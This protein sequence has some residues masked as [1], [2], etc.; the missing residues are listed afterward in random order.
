MSEWWLGAP[1]SITGMHHSGTS[2]V[3]ELLHR[4]GLYLGR[5]DQ[6]FASGSDNPD[7]YWEHKGFRA[8]NERILRI[9]G[10]GRNLP[11]SLPAGWQ[12]DERLRPLRS[13]AK[14]LL[15][16]FDGHERWGWKD[17]RNSL[18]LPFWKSLVPGVKVVVC[19]R[20][21]LQVAFEL[22]QRN[23]SSYASGLK[24]W[25]VYNQRLLSTLPTDRYIVT[26]YD[27]YFYRPQVEL[28][29]VLD[30]LRLPASDQLV[31][32]VSSSTLGNLRYGHVTTQQ[33]L[34]ADAYPQL[35]ELYLRLCR[36]AGWRHDHLIVSSTGG[37]EDVAGRPLI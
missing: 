3:A 12:E 14:R 23:R 6:L 18:T 33:S 9:Y 4:C 2:T 17:P 30:F 10:G 5:E 11:P 22:S 19:L 29:R 32:R 36:E 37:G 31:A 34:E 27:T 20:N 24:L 35:F 16:E 21:P 15:R 25:T 1:V 28:R 13:E 26:H 8:I 7:E